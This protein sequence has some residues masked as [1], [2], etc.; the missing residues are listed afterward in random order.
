M[1]N[2]ILII[3]LLGMLQNVH[4]TFIGDNFDLGF[5]AYPAEA[6]AFLNGVAGSASDDIIYT[7]IPAD[8]IVNFLSAD[9]FTINLTGNQTDFLNI[10]LAWTLL[11]L[12]WSVSGFEIS[13][14]SLLSSSAD[15]GFLGASFNSNSVNVGMGQV[16]YVSGQS[17]TATFQISVSEVQVPEP[18]SLALLGLGL[19]GF[20]FTR[21]K[22]N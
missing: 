14:I 9:T 5:A 7:S 19:M 16:N 6:A 10:D 3:M 8:Y 18:T 20:G 2:T 13:G 1:K 12:D 11:D 17:I 4:A 21:K 22:Q 15:F